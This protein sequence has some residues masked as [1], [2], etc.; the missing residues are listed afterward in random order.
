[1][2][3]DANLESPDC[4][5]PAKLAGIELPLGTL[6]YGE[7]V[8]NSK[9]GAVKAFNIVEAFVIDLEDVREL[10]F[11]NR[12]QECEYLAS[13]CRKNNCVVTVADSLEDSSVGDKSFSGIAKKLL[14]FQ[15]AHR[16]LL[17]MDFIIDGRTPEEN[18]KNMIESFVNRKIFSTNLKENL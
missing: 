5:E 16:G 1:M 15:S 18:R 8:R 17:S 7:E 2:R 12:R 6:I 11:A 9:S 10:S 4:L 13:Q 3:F 14:E